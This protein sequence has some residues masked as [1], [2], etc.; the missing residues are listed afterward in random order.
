MSG[1]KK[2]F[3]TLNDDRNQCLNYL[4]QQRKLTFQLMSLSMDSVSSLAHA[5]RALSSP[6]C[7]YAQIEMEVLASTLESVPSVHLWTNI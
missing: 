4:T 2:S 6:E 1:R 5:S 3:N 7:N